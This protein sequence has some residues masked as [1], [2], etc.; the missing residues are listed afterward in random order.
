MSFPPAEPAGSRCTGVAQPGSTALMAW[1]LETFGTKGARNYGIYNCRV[2]AGTTV[3]STH[4]EG[5]AID[6]G[7]A[8][9]NGKANPNG[10]ALANRLIGKASQL[11]IQRIIW[12]RTVWD[13]RNPGGRPYTG[14]SPHYDHI[15][16]EQLWSSA[17]TLTLARIRQIMSPPVVKPPAPTPTPKPP[18]PSTHEDHDVTAYIKLVIA[19]HP[20]NGRVE[21]VGDFHRRH[22]SSHDEMAMLQFFGA[23][24]QNVTDRAT[25]NKLTANKTVVNGAGIKA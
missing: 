18:A 11:G 5:R 13:F 19:G 23:K 12:N 21:A 3:R 14:V 8:L 10:T 20:H 16:A 15:H 6:V 4:G 1:C 2:V 22:I 24:I 17:R 7:F 9:V 25:W